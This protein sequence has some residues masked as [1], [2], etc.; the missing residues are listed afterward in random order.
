VPP[1]PVCGAEL[2]AGVLALAPEL[3]AGVPVA[4]L[5]AVAPAEALAPAPALLFVVEWPEAAP[6]AAPEAV[7]DDEVVDVGGG[8]DAPDDE[9]VEDPEHPASAT[10]RMAKTP[11]PLTVGI[12]L[13]TVPAMVPRTV[14]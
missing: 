5:D 10:T 9:E 12:A 7:A 14:M 1:P 2:F 4:W 3:G 11:K 6:E 13:S 8:L